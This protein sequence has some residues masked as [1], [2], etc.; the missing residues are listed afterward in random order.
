MI[1]KVEELVPE[2]HMP[3]LLQVVDFDSVDMIIILQGPVV[4]KVINANPRLKI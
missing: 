4:Q 2:C 1:L 3:L